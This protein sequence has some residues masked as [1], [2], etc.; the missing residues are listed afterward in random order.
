[1]HETSGRASDDF[2]LFVKTSLSVGSGWKDHPGGMHGQLARV[3][4]CLDL[5]PSTTVLGQRENA[6]SGN[7]AMARV[8]R[9]V[10]QSRHTEL[11]LEVKTPHSTTTRLGLRELQV[12]SCYSAALSL[13]VCIAV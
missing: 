3:C 11:S 7:R 10:I 9:A 2:K 6:R 8:N 1:M 4:I 5:Q 13:H 12:D